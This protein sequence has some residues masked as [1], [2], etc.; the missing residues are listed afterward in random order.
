LIHFYSE[1]NTDPYDFKKGGLS[2][3]RGRSHFFQYN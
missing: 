2:L 3:K 1:I